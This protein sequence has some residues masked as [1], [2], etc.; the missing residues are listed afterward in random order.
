MGLAD[1]FKKKATP[2]EHEHAWLP[3]GKYWG[4]NSKENDQRLFEGDHLRPEVRDYFMHKM[5]FLMGKLNLSGW[6]KW[7]KVYFAGSEAAKW[8]PFNGDLDCLVGIDYDKFR[9]DNSVYG[10][11]SNEGISEYLTGQMRTH[12]NN[13]G[14]YIEVAGRNVGPLDSTFYVNPNS[15]DI[16]DIKPYAAYDVTE[17][18][19]AVH[20]LEVPEGWSAQSLPESFWDVS[21][22]E[23]NLINVISE[24]PAVERKRV[25]GQVWEM[26]H[27]G[28]KAAFN[29]GGKSMFDFNNVLEKYLD[30]R[31]DHPLAR[32]IAMKDATVDDSAPAWQPP[33]PELSKAAA[34]DDQGV[35][36]AIVPPM[37]VC[38]QMVQEKG[39]EP[40]EEMHVTLCYMGSLEELTPRQRRALPDLVQNW[41][42]AQQN[43]KAKINGV[44]TFA[45]PGNHALWMSPDIPHSSAMRESL[46]R[47][48][49]AHG[50]P[51]YHN[52]GWAPHITIAY[53]KYNHRFLPKPVEA[54]WDI[55]GVEVWMGGKH[56]PI[57]FGKRV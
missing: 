12:L 18:K 17:D 40:P 5:A 15:Y 11:M 46:V 36:V 34:R 2:Y 29:E 41:A 51:I 9:K 38:R 8:A 27:T 50:Y 35:I 16:R 39:S 57:A 28:R 52:H 30:Q 55:E 23:A 44:G 25:A 20:P 48:L 3:E 45:N 22:A 37:D 1:L 24:L 14:T 42:V 10:S 56:I 31:P 13:P 6:T 43:L 21:E 33:Q 19:W 54:S 32:L 47:Y 49:E 7:T 53:S 26:I 4:E